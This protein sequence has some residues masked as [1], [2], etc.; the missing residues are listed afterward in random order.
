MYL[1]A[2][3]SG[4]I[5]P[6]SAVS[7]NLSV[8]RDQASSNSAPSDSTPRVLA[9]PEF[10]SQLREQGSLPE[11]PSRGPGDDAGLV[12]RCCEVYNAA[13]HRDGVSKR[14]INFRL[15]M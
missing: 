13:R 2:V 9:L 15:Y 7:N 5:S 12:E 4:S 14:M 3:M 8:I 1:C 6:L 11:E 10:L